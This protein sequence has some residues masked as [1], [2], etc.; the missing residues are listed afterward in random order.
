MPLI[1]FNISIIVMFAV[2]H[3]IIK[4]IYKK[5]Y[6]LKFA[7]SILMGILTALIYD[8]IPLTCYLIIKIHNYIK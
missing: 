2:I 7:G 4:P 1:I 5:R 8:L 6:P 3:I